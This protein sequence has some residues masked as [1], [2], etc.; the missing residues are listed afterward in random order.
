[1]IV[2]GLLLTYE[3]HSHEFLSKFKVPGGH[4]VLLVEWALNPFRKWLVNISATVDHTDI[5]CHTS[6]YCNSQGYSCVGKWMAPLR[7]LS[8]TM[9]ASYQGSKLPSRY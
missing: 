8:G 3:L 6:H 1:M 2:V 4:V 9:K 7:A 5:S